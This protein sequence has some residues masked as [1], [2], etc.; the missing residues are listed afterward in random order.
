MKDLNIWRIT[1]D[2]NPEDCN[3]HCIMCEEH[4]NYSDFKQKLFNKT[5]IKRRLMPKEWLEAI[6]KEVKELGVKEII[7]STMGEPLLYEYFE[8]I[9]K[10][11]LYCP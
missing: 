8:V 3:F 9:L 11:L 10:Y 5:G 4:S 1:L 7:P 6:F 2:T